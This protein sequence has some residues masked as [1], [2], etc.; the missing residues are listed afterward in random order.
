MDLADPLETDKTKD[1]SMEQLQRIV[2][3]RQIKVL[4]LKQA[5]LERDIGASDIPVLFDISSLNV[6]GLPDANANI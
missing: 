5:K 6:S 1:L 3:L 4:E 2:L